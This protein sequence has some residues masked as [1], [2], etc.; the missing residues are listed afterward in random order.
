MVA[1]TGFSQSAHI[2]VQREGRI[3][4]IPSTGLRCFEEPN[5]VSGENNAQVTWAQLLFA[6][7]LRGCRG[8]RSPF[9]STSADSRTEHK[10][11]SYF[12]CQLAL[13]RIYR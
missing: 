5:R 6:V 8:G 11:H 12:Y 10:T 13:E 3:D 7:G 4:P 2:W 1:P 9:E